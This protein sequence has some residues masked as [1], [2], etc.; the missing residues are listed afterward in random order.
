[1]VDTLKADGVIYPYV[2]D[3]DSRDTVEF[4]T[5][6]GTVNWN[7]K[8]INVNEDEYLITTSTSTT[9]DGLLLIICNTDENKKIILVYD[10][11]GLSQIEIPSDR[12]IYSANTVDLWAERANHN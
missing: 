3:W 4:R 11:E 10:E 6:V 7:T 1:M 12:T 9:E 2:I 8:L 5:I